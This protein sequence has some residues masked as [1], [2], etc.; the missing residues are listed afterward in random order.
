MK[1]VGLLSGG[2]DSI[3]A[4]KLI[5]EQ[6]IDVTLLSFKTP[7]FDCGK[8]KTAYLKQTARHLGVKLKIIDITSD[9]IRMLRKPKHGYGKNM[10]PCIDCKILMLK[11]AKEYAKK[12]DA[13]FIFTGEVLGQRPMSQQLSQLHL[14]ENEAGLKR[15][16]LRPLSAKLLPETEAETNGWIDRN[17]LESIHGR[18]RNLQM[19]LAKRY[20]IKEYQSPAGGCLLTCELYCRKV[21]DLFVHTRKNSAHDIRL[22]KLGRHFRFGKN[23]ILVGRNERDN[24]LLLKVKDDSEYKFMAYR[25]NGPITLLQGPKTKKAITLAAQLTARYCD[26][27]AGN[28]KIA[29]GNRRFDKKIIVQKSSPEEIERYRI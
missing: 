17:Q 13:R 15:K 24:R 7:F 18:G 29:Y 9:Y 1:A 10:N 2:L 27:G 20:G 11:N 5:A 16:L 8:E 23:K 22:L 25:H 12:S 21:K 28:V 6:G 14:I 19:E 4:A 3:L 26:A